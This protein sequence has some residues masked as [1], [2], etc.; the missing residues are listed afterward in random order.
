[1]QGVFL[2]FFETDYLRIITDNFVFIYIL[3]P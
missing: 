3:G 2:A 1:M